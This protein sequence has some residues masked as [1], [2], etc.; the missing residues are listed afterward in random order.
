MKY[1]CLKV[2]SFQLLGL[3]ILQMKIYGYVKRHQVDT[4][5]NVFL[6]LKKVEPRNKIKEKLYYTHLGDL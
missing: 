3:Q 1:V 6:T 4:K 5:T 2:L